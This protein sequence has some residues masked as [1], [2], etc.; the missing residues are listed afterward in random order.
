M[1]AA[2]PASLLRKQLGACGGLAATTAQATAVKIRLTPRYVTRL[3][4]NNPSHGDNFGE[5][6]YEEDILDALEMHKN[7]LLIGRRLGN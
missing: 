7:S 5:E 6:E 3:C 4:C 2:A 1:L